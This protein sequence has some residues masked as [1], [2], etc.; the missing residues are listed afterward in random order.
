[1][2][3][4]Y[5]RIGK[6]ATLE[7]AAEECAE[8][9]HALL[10]EARRLRGENPTP[11]TAIECGKAIQEEISDVLLCLQ[12]LLRTGYAA[13]PELLEDK[14]QRWHTRLDE[15]EAKKAA[16]GADTRQP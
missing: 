12:E 4:I 1:M 15:A 7:Q 5:Q 8:L 11:K 3:P 9:A 6:P 14:R 2:K 10:K 13:D 16:A